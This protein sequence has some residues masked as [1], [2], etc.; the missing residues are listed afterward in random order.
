MKNSKSDSESSM[1]FLGRMTG[2]TETGRLRGPM[3][4]NIMRSSK[5]FGQ[6]VKGDPKKRKCGRTDGHHLLIV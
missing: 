2:K 4:S 5:I 1:S 6:V 3:P